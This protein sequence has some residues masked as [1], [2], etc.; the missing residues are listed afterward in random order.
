MKKINHGLYIALVLVLF[1]GY[2]YA[3][4]S[5]TS[6][7]IPTA[8]F[9]A[10]GAAL[11]SDNYLMDATLGQSTALMGNDLPPSS[12]NYTLYPGFWYTVEAT[13]TDSDGDGVPDC[14]AQ[15]ISEQQGTCSASSD[16]PGVPCSSD[17]DC[18]DGCSSKGQCL[19][20][21]AGSS[22]VCDNC[23]YDPIKI[24]PGICGCGVAD[25]IDSD[26]DGVPD[27]VDNCP[28]VANPDQADSDGKGKGNVC[29]YVFDGFFE[30]INNGEVVNVAKA[31]QA[32]PVKWR[33]TDYGNGTPIS[34][35][36]SFV[37]L[38][39]YS[40][41]CVDFTGEPVD[42]I[43]EYASGAIGL[44]YIGD[45]NWQFNWKTPKTYVGQCR[46]MYIKFSVGTTS[47]LAKFKFK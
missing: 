33:L 17:A 42:V 24:E 45:G 1:T 20:I 27:C 4:M 15:P 3:L 19:Q 34:D 35:P 37:G 41:S 14:P 40:V 47:P 6:Y 10:G 9:S 7:Q 12:E 36:A 39:S 46:Q 2:A 8:E 23:P 18:A 43:E 13:G 22:D 21:E 16:K 25:D 29:E 26:G 28:T 31:E 30:P 32:I 44:Q 38:Y 11:S 5:S